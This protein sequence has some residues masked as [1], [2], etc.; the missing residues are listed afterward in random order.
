MPKA[1]AVSAL[2]IAMSASCEAVGFG[3]TAQSPKTSTCSGRHMKNTLETS[4][5]PGTVLI[6]CNAGRMVCAVV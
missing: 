1:A 2:C 4:S 6:S 3:T 5:Q